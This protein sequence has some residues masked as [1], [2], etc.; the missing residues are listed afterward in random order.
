MTPTEGPDFTTLDSTDFEQFCFEL[1]GGLDGFA[2][3][4]WRKG[5]PKNTSP[6][7]RGRDI[8]AEVER[9]D[10][11]GSK[12]AETWF[13]DCKHHAKGSGRLKGPRH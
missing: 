5:T 3:V 7:D 11:D 10:V 4:D 12:H 2:N 13:V 1:L 9:T 6:A 8:V